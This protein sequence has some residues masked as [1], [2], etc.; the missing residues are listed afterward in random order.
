MTG[1]AIAAFFLAETSLQLLMIS[2]FFAIANGLSMANLSGLIS[3]SAGADIQGEILG[4]NASVQAFG[5]FLPPL[6]AGFVAA[7]FAAEIPI[8]LA[9]LVILSAGIIFALF[10]RTL[11]AVL[12]RSTME[13]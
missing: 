9:S 8:A 5:Q 12:Q 2:P 1:I 13:T 4:I 10:R 7:N 6:I 11:P 3:R